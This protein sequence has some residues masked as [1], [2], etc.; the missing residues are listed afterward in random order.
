FE[1]LELGQLMN[2]TVDRFRPFAVNLGV[3]IN[4][5]RPI[6]PY[7]IKGDRKRLD[8][9]LMNLLSNAAKFSDGHGVIRVSLNLNEDMVRLSVAD[10]GI[11]IA[12]NMEEA[13]FAEFIQLDGQDSRKFG[14]TGLGLSISKRIVEAHG[15]VI[16]YDSEPGVGTT[17]YVDMH[18]ASK[19]KESKTWKAA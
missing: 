6:E 7:W 2:E 9:V 15:G 10:R 16:G 3:D 1:T 5:V 12:E 19:P 13:V 17:F 11:G 18:K 4:T 8:Q 14:G